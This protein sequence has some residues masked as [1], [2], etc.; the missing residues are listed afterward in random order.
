VLHRLGAPLSDA[1]WWIPLGCY[2]LSA[3]LFLAWAARHL[4]LA[5]AALFAL[6]LAHT[7]ALL[8]QAST[9]SADGLAALC[10]CLGAWALLERRSLALAAAPL[11]LAVAA[12][13]D[14]VLLVGFG[15]AALYG[16][17]PRA[18]RPGLRALAAWLAA[19]GLLFLGLARFAGEYGWWPLIQIS[20][21][22]KAVHPSTLATAPDW[23]QYGAILWR[24]VSALPGD[25]YTTTPSGD[26]TGSSLVLFYAALAVLALAFA[27]RHGRHRTAALLAALL[28]T[29]LVRFLLFPQLWDRFLASFYALVPL[30]LLA[31]LSGE[32]RARARPG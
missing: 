21:V 7:P 9:S 32:L 6:G 22:E 23:E 27:V 28:A 1:T 20:F 2:A 29:Y 11:T 15:A 30:C 24:Q 14:S 10:T 25:G 31:L 4:P 13:P 19:T 17:L 18:E 26:V 3:A 12:R 8:N 16:M 5:F